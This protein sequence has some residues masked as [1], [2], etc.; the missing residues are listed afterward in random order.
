LLGWKSIKALAACENCT[1]HHK[2]TQI[3]NIFFDAATKQLLYLFLK[4]NPENKTVSE[5]YKFADKKNKNYKCLL[6]FTFTFLLAWKLLKS[7]MRRSN[8]RFIQMCMEKLS[9]IFYG[10][11]MTNY[12]DIWVRFDK[13]MQT[14]PEQAR[15]FIEE[16]LTMSQSGHGSKA[17]GGAF[18]LE[19][20]NE[21][22]KAYMPA[23]VPTEECLARVCKNLDAIER[24]IHVK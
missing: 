5:F 7:R 9:T 20:A 8:F 13:I 24:Y 11:N 14:L 6:S 21:K 1:D 18:I 15:A 3:L 23:G 12:M 17:E 22:M 19:S 2:A 10:T 4:S 16:D